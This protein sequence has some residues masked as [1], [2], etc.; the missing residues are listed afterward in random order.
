MK[1]LISILLTMAMMIGVI[2]AMPAMP[3]SAANVEDL[4]S[5]KQN[6]GSVLHFEFV[7]IA[8]NGDTYVALAKPNSNWGY[9]RLL[10]SHDGGMTWAT[11]TTKYNN[12]LSVNPR[13]QQ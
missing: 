2:T 7:D 8:H 5:L 11:A 4:L 13:S 12:P 10:Y 1:K 9:S 6:D 3:A